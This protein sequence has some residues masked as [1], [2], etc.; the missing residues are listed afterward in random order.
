MRDDGLI[1]GVGI[2]TAT[3]DQ[4]AQAI[5]DAGI[6]T[7]QN[8]YSLV[9]RNDEDV[10]ALCAQHAVSYVPYFPLGYAF[11]GMPKVV[12]D[13]V[14]QRTAAAVGVTPARV[15]LA[16]LLAHDP[17]V[18]LIPGRAAEQAVGV[19]SECARVGR[20]ADI[21]V[22]GRLF[23]SQV[24][25]TRPLQGGH[26]AWARI[27]SNSCLRLRTTIDGEMWAAPTAGRILGSTPQNDIVKKSDAPKG[28]SAA[29]LDE[30][31]AGAARGRAAT[32]V[33]PR[34]Q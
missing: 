33:L 2:S 18:L 24:A 30:P 6:V 34:G 29:L 5:R 12:D 31:A 13:P 16:W 8:A 14:V 11:P 32:R 19:P 7:V 23:Q 10:L 15:G 20:T 26:E 3:R 27:S 25:I 28:A 9:S 17:H 22:T 4:V 1:A 21:S